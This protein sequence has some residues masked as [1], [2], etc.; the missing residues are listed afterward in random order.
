MQAAAL[1]AERT[2]A[3][4]SPAYLRS[5]FGTAEWAAAFAND[6]T[7]SE[8]KLVPVRVADCVPTGLLA[9]VVYIDLVDC[10]ASQAEET[11]L[12][13]V[14]GAQTG[15]TSNRL[16]TRP[17]F[18]GAHRN[19]P[20]AMNSAPRYPGELPPCWTVP[21]RSNRYFVGR[22]EALEQLH[23]LLHAGRAVPVLTGLGGIGKTRLAGEYAWAYKAD[24]DAVLWVA[25][26]SPEAL[27]TNLA[28]LTSDKA[29]SLSAQAD[30]LV[31]VT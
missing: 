12:Q 8:R 22:E 11:L 23:Q 10:E 6:P 29:L 31:E 4:L 14:R 17:S 26:D 9:A 19:P 20:S 16:G 2:L 28:A 21:F 24:Y 30:K 13:G 27:S 5:S 1:K 15:L 7:G 25:A 3:V 18:P